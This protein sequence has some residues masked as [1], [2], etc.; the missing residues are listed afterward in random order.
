MKKILIID[1]N[2]TYVLNNMNKT[3]GGAAVQTFNWICGFD[4][5]GYNVI[6]LSENKISEN[7][8][9]YKIINDYQFNNKNFIISFLSAFV[10]YYRTFRSI[11]PDYI[12]CSIPWWNRILYILPAKIIGIKFIQRISNDN[13]VEKR[14]AHIFNNRIKNL[15]FRISLN[16][17]KNIICQNDYQYDSLI[18]RFPKKNIQKL[19]NPFKF[20]NIDYFGSKNYVAWV[21]LFQKQK[22]LPELLKIVLS[23]PEINFM[24]AGKEIS[25]GSL[26]SLTHSALIKLN[27]LNNVTFVG[28]LDRK[29]IFS[30]L[31]NAFCLLNTSHEEGFSNTYLEAFSV[32]TPVVTRK[33]TDPDNIISTFNLGISVNTY[34]L[35]PQAILDILSNNINYKKRMID[36]LAYYHDPVK[37]S[38]QLINQAK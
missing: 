25:N 23:L 18:N 1:S 8:T 20:H 11:S 9:K 32:G 3:T 24:I 4:N 5:L 14:L 12:Y 35:I 10:F 37:L 2:V 38:K 6:I 30:F 34:E 16:L 31:S 33:K 22:N 7:K 29:E 17:S 36:Y 13:L 27:N 15:L 28:N 26:D 19:Y 21:G